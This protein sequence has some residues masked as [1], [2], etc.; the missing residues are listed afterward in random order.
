MIHDFF[1]DSIELGVDEAEEVRSALF[2]ESGA[3]PG[4]PQGYLLLQ[5]SVAGIGDPDLKEPYV[6]LNDAG[7][8]RFAQ[9]VEFGE[10]LPTYLH[11]HLAPDSSIVLSED[12]RERPVSDIVVRFHADATLLRRMRHALS[13]VVADGF[14]LR[15]VN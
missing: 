8:G 4:P 15:F 1:A 14:P 12:G 6:E 13:L 10:L 3:A 11:L 5:R 9:S 7:N 2:T